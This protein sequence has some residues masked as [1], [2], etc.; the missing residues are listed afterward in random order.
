MLE[1]PF[2][3]EGSEEDLISYRKVKPWVGKFKNLTVTKFEGERGANTRIEFEN[4]VLHFESLNIG[5]SGEGPGCL[6]QILAEIG[7]NR[8]VAEKA[9]FTSKYS[10][11]AQRISIFRMEM[12][13]GNP[14]Y[15]EIEYIVF[16]ENSYP[17]MELRPEYN[18]RR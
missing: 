5:Y 14:V 17:G 7:F 15:E 10:L 4:G 18:G 13:N 1:F 8:K 6:V 11:H 3:S 16:F 9:V 12:G 2:T